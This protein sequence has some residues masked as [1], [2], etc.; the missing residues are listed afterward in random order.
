MRM[1]PCFPLE[2]CLLPPGG[3]DA[4]SLFNIDPGSWDPGPTAEDPPQPSSQLHSLCN[5]N[6]EHITEHIDVKYV[7]LQ[8]KNHAQYY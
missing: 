8:W 3:Q 4:A 1:C 5:I 7:N 2:R 6:R